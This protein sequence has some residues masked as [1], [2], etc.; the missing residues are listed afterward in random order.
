MENTDIDRVVEDGIGLIG[1]AEELYCASLAELALEDDKI[2][3]MIYCSQPFIGFLPSRAMPTGVR[4]SILI[5]NDT[6]AG[7]MRIGDNQIRVWRQ[8]AADEIT[9][10]R[11]VRCVWKAY[12]HLLQFDQSS[13]KKFGFSRNP[14]L[15]VID[16]WPV[17]RGQT[18]PPSPFAKIIEDA[19][20]EMMKFLTICQEILP[21][22][23][24]GQNQPSDFATFQSVEGSCFPRLFS[25][26]GQELAKH[27]RDF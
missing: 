7:F 27:L 3:S 19:K 24:I 10:V 26:P 14:R 20:E 12:G 25:G 16:T 4:N 23:L 15:S 17:F 11:V 8:G 18:M 2:S 5:E 9:E 6:G 22:R 13:A 21:I 1:G